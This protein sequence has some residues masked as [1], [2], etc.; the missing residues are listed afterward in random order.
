M[1]GETKVL[2]LGGCKSGAACTI[3][4]RGSSHHLLDEAERSLHDALCILAATLTHP[5]RIYG[6]GCT[7]VAMAQAI[8]KAAKETPGKQALAMSSFAKA[9][10]QLPTIVADNGGYDAAELVT[11]LRAAHAAGNTSYGLNMI[12][13]TIGS[14][15]E[16]G[17]MESYKSK[18]QVLTSAAEASE[19]ILR[20]DDIIKCAPR[21]REEMM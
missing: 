1:I 18:L 3:V 14:M 21:R 15:D 17:I 11:Q 4:L 5:R 6:G 7:E 19:M 20:V 9:L 12:N 8:D 2:R 10:L 13:G 16:L